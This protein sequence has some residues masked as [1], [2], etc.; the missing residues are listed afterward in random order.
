MDYN[1]KLVKPQYDFTSI[2]FDYP[3][4]KNN[5]PNY[6][7]LSGTRNFYRKFQNKT[8]SSRFNFNVIV[9]GN[10]TLVSNANDLG[11]N[12][13]FRMFI[14]LPNT[15]NSQETG[16]MN[17]RLPFQ[18]GQTGDDAGCRTGGNPDNM[19]NTLSQ[20]NNGTEFSVTA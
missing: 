14:K 19:L 12:N 4:D 7:N 2:N 5:A 6:E 15:T 8:F 9:S 3:G 17:V 18:T 1:E 16:Y 20:V 11:N 10:G 13:N